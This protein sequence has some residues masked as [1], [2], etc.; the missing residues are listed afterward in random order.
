M[1]SFLA[2][3]LELSALSVSG[4]I[5]PRHRLLARDVVT[6]ST[7]DTNYLEP[8]FNYHARYLALGCEYNHGNDFFAACCHPML[9]NETL[10]DLDP[11]C[12]PDP[13]VVSSV[14][15]SLEGVTS[16][17]ASASSTSAPASTTEV[18]VA[19]NIQESS[20][21]SWTPTTTWSSSSAP[22]TTWSSSSSWTPSS[23]SSAAASTGSVM[24]GG[25]GTWFN[26]NGVA[27]A[28]GT[29]HQDT[30]QI[31][32]MDSAIYNQGLCGKQV[33]ITNTANGQSVVA[34]VADE[35]P[36]CNNANSIDMSLGTFEALADLGVGLLT[37]SWVWDD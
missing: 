36:T 31:V 22:A 15:A 29:V 32:A 30:D 8:Y 26:Q 13:T 10:S 19:Q 4:R 9:K 33:K 21:S 7:Y 17:S 37:I 28:C 14:S 11:R 27:G 1:L 12:T 16:S 23:S 2:V 35:C 18:A 3:T 6:P 20:S 34:T 5:M 24:T 25:F